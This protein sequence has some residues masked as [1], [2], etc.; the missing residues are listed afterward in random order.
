VT[1]TPPLPPPP[2]TEPPPPLPGSLPP[3]GTQAAPRPDDGPPARSAAAP[4]A[5]ALV[6]TLVVALG[7]F[8]LVSWARGGS[9]CPDGAFESTRFGYCATPP[10]GWLAAAA[11]GP[12]ALDRF[13]VPDG[14]GTVTVTATALDKGQ[15]LARFEQFVRGYVE[16][17]GGDAGDAS[18]LEV[19]GADGLAFD[20]TLEGPDGT[21]RSREVLLARDDVAWRITLADE[22]SAFDASARQLDAMLDTWRF[23]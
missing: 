15:D 1:A 11:E 8:A 7:G 4:V 10:A 20:V 23:T 5:L 16:E 17:A 12:G 9:S 22:A 19:D 18:A 2:G 21:V 3:G 14:A 13:L 6:L